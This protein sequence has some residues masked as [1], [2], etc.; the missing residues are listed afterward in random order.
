LH[1]KAVCGLVTLKGRFRLLHNLIPLILREFPAV[2][3]DIAHPGQ[4]A[5]KPREN[6]HLVMEVAEENPAVL[7]V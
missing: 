4:L 3:V 7:S 6:V 1:K 2:L 5:K